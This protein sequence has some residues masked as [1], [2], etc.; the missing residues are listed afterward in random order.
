MKQDS[1]VSAW[2]ANRDVNDVL[3]KGETAVL[4]ARIHPAIFWKGV[5]I[6]LF[7]LFVAVWFK[8]LGLLFLCSGFFA[9]ILEWL[10]KRFLLMVL[11][12]KRVLMR[13]GIMFQ[14]V[15]DIHQNRIESVETSRTLIGQIFGYA[16]VIITGMGN[17]VVIVPFV[18][19]ANEMRKAIEEIV[20]ARLDKE[21]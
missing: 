3:T 18:A 15:I 5:V 16:S 14:D 4:M 20:Y 11:T 7:G 21:G 1:S 2:I 19:N 8:W 17:R 9:L 10:T 13:T 12:N 6:T